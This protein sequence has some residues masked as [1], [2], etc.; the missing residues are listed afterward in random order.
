[1]L[2][3]WTVHHK[4][5]RN[6]NKSQILQLIPGIACSGYSRRTLYRPLGLKS[7]VKSES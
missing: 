3:R 7:S 4:R 1:M 5:P 2:V 6:Y